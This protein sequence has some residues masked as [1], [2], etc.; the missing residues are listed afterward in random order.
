M[1]AAAD[2]AS[3][4]TATATTKKKKKKGKT[5]CGLRASCAEEQ[6]VA[7]VEE[8]RCW[9]GGKKKTHIV[10]DKTVGRED[11]KT[12]FLFQDPNKSTVRRGRVMQH[13]RETSHVVCV[14]RGA[15]VGYG[16]SHTG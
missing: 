8:R 6:D 10:G 1:R 9:A 3:R 4:R 7:S 2:A 15:E 13:L 11:G 5:V 12:I 16:V 14:L